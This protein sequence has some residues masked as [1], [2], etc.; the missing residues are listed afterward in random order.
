MQTS[1]KSDVEDQVG[2]WNLG[3][4]LSMSG[5]SSECWVV[6]EEKGQDGGGNEI[7]G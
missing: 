3:L 1:S 6:G 2:K 7:L 4:R 5:R